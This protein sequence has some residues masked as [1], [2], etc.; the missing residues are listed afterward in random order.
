MEDNYIKPMNDSF[1]TQTKSAVKLIKN[2]KGITWEIK[3]VA[4]EEHL[5]D[6][7]MH[8][9]VKQHKELMKLI[10]VEKEEKK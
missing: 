2:S 8:E 5:I 3:V 1:I 9:A 7:L 6:G 4:G 10:E